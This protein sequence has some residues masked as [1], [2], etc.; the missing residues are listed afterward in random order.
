M[1][2]VRNI[3]MVQTGLI[4]IP[5]SITGDDDDEDIQTTDEGNRRVQTHNNHIDEITVRGLSGM[6]TIRI[7][8]GD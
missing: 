8:T 6:D 1:V 5:V 4:N 7:F 3:Y 2:S